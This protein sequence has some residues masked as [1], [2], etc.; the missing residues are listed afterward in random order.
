MV[1]VCPPGSSVTVAEEVADRDVRCVGRWRMMIDRDE[2]GL[3]AGTSQATEWQAQQKLQAAAKVLPC[4]THAAA[5]AV[6]M[7]ALPFRPARPAPVLV[8]FLFVCPARARPRPSNCFA[9]SSASLPAFCL[10]VL[11]QSSLILPHVPPTPTIEKKGYREVHVCGSRKREGG[12][13][14][15]DARDDRACMAM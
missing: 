8:S 2:E 11:L 13:R 1:M 6:C 9:L 3:S 10:P 14:A 5:G 7:P 12:R 15:G 4:Q